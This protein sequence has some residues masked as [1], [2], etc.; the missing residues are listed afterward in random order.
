MLHIGWLFGVKK[1]M[2]KV[3]FYNPSG[4]QVGIFDTEDG[5]YS[6]IKDARKHLFFKFGNALA[7]SEYILKKLERLNC[8]KLRI[9]ITNFESEVFDAVIDFKTFM[10]KSKTIFYRGQKLSDKQKMLELSSWSRVYSN[11]KRLQ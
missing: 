5:V 8:Q 2:T 3:P 11:Q 4:R 9:T 6:Q 10:K 7:F 1:N